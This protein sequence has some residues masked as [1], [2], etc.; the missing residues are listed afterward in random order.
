MYLRTNNLIKNILSTCY[1][2]ILIFKLNFF[3]KK[4]NLQDLLD[5]AYKYFNYP[6][7]F[8]QIEE[9]IKDLLKVLYII[10][11]K[12]VLE[13]GTAGG[14]SLF[15]LSQVISDDANLISIDMPNGRFGGGYPKY[16][17]PLYKLLAKKNQKI[18]LIRKD[19][20]SLVTYNKVKSVLKG[21]K[22]DFIFI[23]GD[24]TYEGVKKDFELYSTLVSE[25]GII[26]FHDIVNGS[27]KNVGG[28]PRYWSEL[29]QNYKYNEFVKDWDQEGYGIG[30]IYL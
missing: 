10:E 2:I 9:E 16:R 24:H 11:P 20:H 22:L 5:F 27:E 13:I 12:Y 6:I 28:V 29:K 25:N 4:R 26:A 14:G 1:L 17:I 18:Y 23:D 15:L 30:F 8:W 21:Q 3:N 19:S 7:L